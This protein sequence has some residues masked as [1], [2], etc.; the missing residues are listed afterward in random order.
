MRVQR[1]HHLGALADRRGHPLDRAGTH[2]ADGEDAA[3]AGFQRTT[4][5]VGVPAV[6]DLAVQ[7]CPF[8]SWPVSTNPWGP[9]P[10]GPG[11]PIGVRL[12]ADEENRWRIGRRTSVPEVP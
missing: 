9:M 4:R 1:R 2:I 7:S 8:K 12:G 3:A 11:Q 5:A 6:Q 10:P